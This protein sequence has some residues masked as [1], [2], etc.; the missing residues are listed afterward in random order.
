ME[1]VEKAMEMLKAYVQKRGAFGQ[2]FSIRVHL[3]RDTSK[4]PLPTQTTIRH[5][6]L[7]KL[8]A[9]Y[10][11][12]RRAVLTKLSQATE[13]LQR[14]PR[15][16]E[17]VLG[18]GLGTMMSKTASSSPLLTLDSVVYMMGA[19][20]EDRRLLQTTAVETVDNNWLS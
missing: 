18:E 7:D 2:P 10:N 16:R 4:V 3:H 5:P 20:L 9:A 17:A 19:Y 14:D 13:V 12:Y 11:G 1:G 6:L 15:L 8:G